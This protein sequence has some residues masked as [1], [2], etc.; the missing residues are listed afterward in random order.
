MPLSQKV[1]HCQRCGMIL[2][3]DLNAA[4]NILKRALNSSSSNFG[5]HV[6]KATE[7]QSGSYASGDLTTTIG[8]QPIASRID[9]LG[10]I[11]GGTYTK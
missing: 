6:A 3:R 5:N 11:F 2:D 9:E 7:G 4:I 8:E 10:T 1:F